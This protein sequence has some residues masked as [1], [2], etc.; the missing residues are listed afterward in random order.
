[1]NALA[2]VSDWTV[3]DGTALTLPRNIFLVG[4]MASGKSRTGEIL[5]RLIG[6]ELVD[7]DVELA[8]RAGR[9]IRE[10]FEEDGEAAF[11]DLERSLIQE[12]ASDYGK[13]I[14]AGGGAFVD[15][16]NQGQ[17]LNNGLVVCLRAE[18]ATIHRRITQAESGGA[19][20]RPLLAGA[21]PL[22]R[23]EALLGQRAEAYSRAH[24]SIDTDLLTSEQVAQEVL[25]VLNETGDETDA[26]TGGK[27]NGR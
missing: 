25:N 15:P 24:Y 18:P 27:E 9:S 5:S 4:F 6:W 1:M 26:G 7:A 21:P 14:A 11:R 8:N 23:I 16:D 10:I 13:V 2:T 20:A 19:A 17:M 3:A 12:L 22:E